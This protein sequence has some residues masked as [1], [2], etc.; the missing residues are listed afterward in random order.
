MRLGVVLAVVGFGAGLCAPAGADEAYRAEIQE[1][2]DAREAGLEAED[3]WLSLV[4]LF[5]LKEG[6][7][8]FGSDP[9]SDMVLPMG[10]SPESAGVFTFED[11]R[12]TLKLER[13][14]DG[15]IDG[16]RVTG[17][18]VMQPDT[19][20]RTDILEVGNVTMYVIERGDR[21]GIR[22]KDKTSPVRTGF[23]GLNWYPIDEGY[24]IEARW[25]SYPSPRPLKVPNV[26]G[27]T[28]IRPSPGHAEF[29]LDGQLVRLDG[30]LQDS[31]SMELFFILRD[32]TSGKETY[33]SG[34][35]LYADPP[36][37]G[38]VILDFNKSY[39][40]PCAFT[41]YATCPLPPK[42]NWLPV[43]VEA[44]EQAYGAAHH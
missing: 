14:V 25:V 21:F 11:G 10:S 23:T 12:T 17:P 41:P 26:L 32:Q 34:R 16:E 2:R 42:Q 39:N 3:G 27:E 37:Q 44:G 29:E 9:S 36:K 19:A 33:G 24:R 6:P 4:G 30:V 28:E 35:F 7:N 8:R 43:K 40:P 31:G 20:D 5:W 13:G 15:R 38:R 22:A 18:R 1:W